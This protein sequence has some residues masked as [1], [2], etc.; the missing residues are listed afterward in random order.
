MNAILKRFQNSPSASLDK[1]VS[2]QSEDFQTLSQLNE[3]LKRVTGISAAVRKKIGDRAGF[4]RLM[5]VART[6]NLAIAT[7]EGSNSAIGATID[8]SP[9][10]KWPRLQVGRTSVA[11]EM[12]YLWKVVA[13]RTILVSGTLYTEIPQIS[14]ETA[15]RALAVSPELVM[16]MEPIHA[17][18]SYTPVTACIISPTFTPDG[19]PR[20]MRPKPDTEG[21]EGVAFQAAFKIW[22]ADISGYITQ[23]HSV[24]AGGTLVLG[25]AF[26]DMAAIEESLHKSLPYAVILTQKSGVRL[27]ALKEQYLLAVRS[28]VR[29]ILLAVGGAWTG[30]DLHDPEIPN[31]LTDLV[32]LNAPFGA[33][34]RSLVRHARAQANG[35]IFE[36]I[37]LMVV[38]VR[39]GVGRL[40][41]SPETPPN[42]RI[43]WLDARIHEASKQGLYMPV[44]RLL[45]KYKM[46][47][48]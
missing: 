21:R 46:L 7:S 17:A 5:Q 38:L 32:I 4:R 34:S 28:G 43:H 2:L 10:K 3:I 20:F 36:I 48:V 40:V 8:W 12:N 16:T 1:V 45:S 13:K 29:P 6:I 35:G 33:I 11:R 15:R 9:Q 18:W 42:R 19:K 24:A 30:F 47:A 26:T 27:S 25:T 23:S 44:K 41:R 37:G 31:A 22:I 39:Q 14:C